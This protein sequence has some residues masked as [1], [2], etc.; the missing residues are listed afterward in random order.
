MAKQ[1]RITIE[2]SEE[3]YQRLVGETRRHNEHFPADNVD[4]RAVAYGLLLT[5]IDRA[6]RAR[7]ENAAK[8]DK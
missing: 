3:D 7:A 8:G 1:R 6:E 4:P 2:L 5:S